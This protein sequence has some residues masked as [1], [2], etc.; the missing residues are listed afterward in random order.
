M[1]VS[2]TNCFVKARAQRK[3]PQEKTSA[4]HN[5]KAKRTMVLVLS[6][7]SLPAWYIPPPLNR[8]YLEYRYRVSPEVATKPRKTRISCIESQ[9]SITES[10]IGMLLPRC[11]PKDHST[12]ALRL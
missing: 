12:S 9:T 10:N 4:T 6:E 5:T 3:Y 11:R 1:P 7:K 8:L 2:Q